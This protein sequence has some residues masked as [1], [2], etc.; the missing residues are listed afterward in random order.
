VVGV[1]QWAEIRWL[2]LV[3][4]RSQPLVARSLGLGV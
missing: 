4:R 2:V 3:A 1:G